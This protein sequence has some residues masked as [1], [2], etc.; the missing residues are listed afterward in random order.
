MPALVRTQESFLDKVDFDSGFQE[1]V[2]LK[3]LDKGDLI[4]GGRNRRSQGVDVRKGETLSQ[5]QNQPQ[6]SDNFDNSSMSWQQAFPAVS[7]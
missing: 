7:F 5:P 2:E 4:A 6:T 3:N 1:C